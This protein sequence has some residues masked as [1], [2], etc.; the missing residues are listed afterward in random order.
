MYRRK[1][2]VRSPNGWDY[3]PRKALVNVY[4]PCKDALLRSQRM[5][6]VMQV[7]LV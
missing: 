7:A 6:V 4:E 1:E 2:T 5:Q 3:V